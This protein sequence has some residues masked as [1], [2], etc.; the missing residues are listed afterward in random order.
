MTAKKTMAWGNT[1]DGVPHGFGRILRRYMF[2]AVRHME[3]PPTTATY[4]WVGLSPLGFVSRCLRIEISSSTSQ[5]TCHGY[6]STWVIISFF[7]TSAARGVVRIRHRNTTGNRRTRT[8][9]EVCAT[10]KLQIWRAKILWGQVYSNSI[11]AL[12]IHVKLTRVSGHSPHS[13]L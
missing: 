3:V 12:F 2:M 10:R 5:V 6:N 7:S 8:F 11:A 9:D 1:Y 13:H 4:A